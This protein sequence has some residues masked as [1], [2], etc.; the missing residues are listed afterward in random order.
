MNTNF[1]LDGDGR[2]NETG[3]TMPM[4]I[5]KNDLSLVKDETRVDSFASNENCEF[6]P[7]SDVVS[8]VEL[9]EESSGGGLVFSNKQEGDFITL[10]PAVLQSFGVEDVVYE[11]NGGYISE[12]KNL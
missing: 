7:N 12:G 9:A 11:V 5:I 8:V 10:Q 1:V 6:G 4:V 3:V 2:G